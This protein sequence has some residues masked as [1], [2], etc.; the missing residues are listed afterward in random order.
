MHIVIIC[1]KNSSINFVRS[2]LKLYQRFIDFSY[3]SALRSDYR[4]TDLSK[5]PLKGLPLSAT[6]SFPLS[7][8]EFPLNMRPAFPSMVQ[9]TLL[10]PYLTQ[11]KTQSI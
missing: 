5:N 3:F 8:Q 11:S 1:D 7:R 10:T 9:D 4:F 6:R 2:S